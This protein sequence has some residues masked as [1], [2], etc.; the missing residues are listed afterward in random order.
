MRKKWIHIDNLTQNKLC[1]L[2]INHSCHFPN[3]LFQSRNEFCRSDILKKVCFSLNQSLQLWKC[4]SLCIFVH[5]GGE[6]IIISF[7]V[8]TE[9][10]PA[11]HS[12][13]L[14]IVLFCVLSGI[15]SWWEGLR[16]SEWRP[17]NLH[18][19]WAT[20]NLK[21]FSSSLL[22]KMKRSFCSNGMLADKH[23]RS[24]CDTSL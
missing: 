7:C 17:R 15:S 14:Y 12:C 18:S 4:S 11:S 13:S 10:T 20:P 3:D 1:V 5:S 24:V 6:V 22:K 21:A 23:S 16:S 8:S 2:Y 9:L 19:C